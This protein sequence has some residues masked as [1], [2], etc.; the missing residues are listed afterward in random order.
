M[1]STVN[2]FNELEKY[3]KDKDVKIFNRSE[4]DILK[5]IG[6]GGSAMVYSATF[7]G[8]EYAIK[9]IKLNI[10]FNKEEFTK[11]KREVCYS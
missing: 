2:Y 6:K 3:L 5:E 8:K 9:S 1:S 10:D 11:F 7:Q 4:D